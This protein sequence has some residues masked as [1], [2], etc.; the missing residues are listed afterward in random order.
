MTRE[1]ALDILQDKSTEFQNLEDEIMMLETSCNID[2][3]TRNAEIVYAKCEQLIVD[4]QRTGQ[5]TLF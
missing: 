5:L 4:L 2:R 3:T 1:Q